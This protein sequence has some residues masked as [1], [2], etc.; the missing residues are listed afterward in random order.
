VMFST[1]P[2]SADT[3]VTF[4]MSLRDGTDIPMP[5]REPLALLR[6]PR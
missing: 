1:R 2:R 4:A 3:N 5:D 6:G